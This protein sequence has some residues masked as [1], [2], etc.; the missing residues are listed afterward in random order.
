MSHLKR[1]KHVAVFFIIINRTKLRKLQQSQEKNHK[2]RKIQEIQKTQKNSC[3]RMS[4]HFEF[5]LLLFSK[6]FIWKLLTLNF[7]LFP[8]Q[9]TKSRWK[10]MNASGTKSLYECFW[11]DDLPAQ[12]LTLNSVFSTHR[13][14]R[15]LFRDICWQPKRK[16]P[17]RKKYEKSCK[18]CFMWSTACEKWI[19]LTY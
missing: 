11:Y 2:N 4:E 1:S 18:M 8:S 15:L 9:M 13:A 10:S 7:L 19:N 5:L 6:L 17:V 16:S 3:L 12:Y 14:S